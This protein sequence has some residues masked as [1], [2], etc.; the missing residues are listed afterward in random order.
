MSALNTSIG[1]AIQRQPATIDFV[2][3]QPVQYDPNAPNLYTDP[4]GRLVSVP[5]PSLAP[6][7]PSIHQPYL[8]T[9]F[10]KDPSNTIGQL[11]R[12]QWADYVQRFSPVENRLMDMTT[13]N[14]PEITAH[15]VERGTATAGQAIDVASRGRA[16][17]RAQY[18]LTARA[19]QQ[20]LEARQDNIA[21][22][23]AVVEAAN[24]IR[25]NL[26]E[27]NR[28]IAV[29]GVPNAGRAYGLSSEG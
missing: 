17:N 13:Y 21:R 2:T 19:G 27:R 5:M 16:L 1:Q 26:I 18:G 7:N 24:R 6:S 25:Q 12:A 11:T 20:A 8:V 14:S 3:R 4:S 29:G 28:N 22:S 23:T 10:D 9:Q 15:E